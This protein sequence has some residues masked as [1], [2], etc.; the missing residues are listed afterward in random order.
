VTKSEK[1]LTE[2]E[3]C[4]EYFDGAFWLRR[5]ELA[6]KE[7]EDVASY[8]YQDR[9]FRVHVG[10]E[11]APDLLGPDGQDDGSVGAQLALAVYGGLGVHGSSLRAI[12][13]VNKYLVTVSYQ[14][15]LS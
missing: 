6:V 14:G 10:L 8:L 3:I 1:V 12:E 7:A 15:K 5:W 4:C 11:G 2:I 9:H 13:M